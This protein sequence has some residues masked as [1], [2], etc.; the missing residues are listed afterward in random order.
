MF[1]LDIPKLNNTFHLI[2]FFFNY[3][4][5]IHISCLLTINKVEQQSLS[6]M[7]VSIFRAVLIAVQ[8]IKQC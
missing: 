1:N 5:N 8:D 6:A 3:N 7:Q 2:A 4:L